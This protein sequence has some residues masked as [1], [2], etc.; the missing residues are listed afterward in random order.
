MMPVADE[1]GRGDGMTQTSGVGRGNAEPLLRG[2]DGG[3][4]QTSGAGLGDAVPE[5][6]HC[7]TERSTAAAPRGGWWHAGRISP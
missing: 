1:P 2:E 7:C 3:A 5:V 4:T 6:G